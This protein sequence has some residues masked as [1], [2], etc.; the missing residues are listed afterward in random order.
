MSITAGIIGIQEG[1]DSGITVKYKVVTDGTEDPLTIL[2]STEIPAR[3]ARFSA[4]SVLTCL[5]RSV[6]VAQ[7]DGTDKDI[8]IATI[9]YG[10]R[11]TGGGG[12]SV[13]L[14]AD[15]GRIQD[16]FFTAKPYD[17]VAEEGYLDDATTK[18]SVTNSAGDPPDPPLMVSVSNV[19]MHLVQREKGTFDPQH[20]VVQTQKINELEVVI[21]GYTIGAKR[22]LLL[23]VEPRLQ[24]DGFFVTTYQI[25]ISVVVRFTRRMLDQGFRHVVDGQ[26]KEIRLSDIN[27][28]VYGF[29]Q[30]EAKNDKFVSDPVKLNGD[31]G[32]SPYEETE[33]WREYR[34][35][36]F[37]DWNTVLDLVRGAP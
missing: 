4:G 17:L 21:A 28:D 26:L 35:N 11:D 14:G 2:T 36:E 37:S 30:P 1:T 23:N 33:A 7:S 29:G 32:V 20:A 18:T 3:G 12:S 22:A 13:T 16:L 24:A 9:E 19:V 10:S 8:W 25:E 6:A 27:P 15:S 31:G 5:N 34:L